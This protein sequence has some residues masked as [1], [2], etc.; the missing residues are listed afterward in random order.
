MATCWLTRQ[1]IVTTNISHRYESASRW[2]SVWNCNYA[3]ITRPSNAGTM[4]W[5]ED[6]IYPK[7]ING[8]LLSENMSYA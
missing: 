5:F 7:I 3:N 8:N 4:S 1:N 2:A 6:I